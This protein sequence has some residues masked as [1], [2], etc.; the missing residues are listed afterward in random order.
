VDST[1][2][3][4]LLDSVD[5]SLVDDTAQIRKKECVSQFIPVYDQLDT[6]VRR[7][8]V[9]DERHAKVTAE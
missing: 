9:S 8:F 3:K 2:D 5:T 4:A 6:H 7:T 1:S